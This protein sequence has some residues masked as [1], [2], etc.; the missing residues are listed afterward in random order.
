MDSVERVI[1][2]WFNA[3]SFDNDIGERD[4]VLAA[5]LL[6]HLESHGIVVEFRNDEED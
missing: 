5:N 2:S 3:N 4:F 1:A 6:A